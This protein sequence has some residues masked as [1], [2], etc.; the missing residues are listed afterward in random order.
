[1]EGIP[2][3]NITIFKT[4]F[5]LEVMVKLVLKEYIVRVWILIMLREREMCHSIII[6]AMNKQ[7]PYRAGKVLKS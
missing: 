6:T 4:S 5:Y 7:L 1:V 2:E 3:G